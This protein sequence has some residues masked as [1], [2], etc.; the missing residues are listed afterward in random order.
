MASI[1]EDTADRG[2]RAE[3]GRHSATRGRTA[4]RLISAFV[5]AALII[6]LPLSAAPYG[7]VEAWWTALFDAAVFLLAA[8][9]AVEGALAGRWLTSAHVV[10]L[11]ILLLAG[12]ATLQSVPLPSTGSISFDP[13]ES[14]LV[15]A[16][17]LAVALY[18]ALLIRY[19]D[20]E[21]RLKFLV[22][23]V[24]LVGLASAFFGIIRQTT[25]RG[26]QGFVL[27]YLS[28]NSGY[29]QF[30]NKNH[31]A[32]LAEMSLGL[33]LGL[34]AGR[35]VA[36]QKILVPLALAVPVWAALVLSNSRGGVLAM[37]C[38][39][40]FLALTFGVTRREGGRAGAAKSAEASAVSRLA[41]S[42]PARVGLAALLLA[43]IAVGT[44][45]VG[46]DPLAE[47]MSAVASEV[48]AEGTDPTRTGRAEIW[49]ATWEMFKGHP[50]AGTGLGGY[51]IA[52]SS[53]HDASGA[54]VPQQ[55]HNDYL[56]LLASGGVVGFALL[57]LFIY[58]FSRR[59]RVRLRGGTPFAR[60]AGLGALAGLFGVAVHSLFEF[61]LHVTANAFTAAALV[62][63]ASAGAW[64]EPKN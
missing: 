57:L 21:G 18:C 17:L 15:A 31:F 6:I 3:S 19:A 13:Y 61:G 14:R 16:R 62:A 45:W 4:A 56:E 48:T 8:L 52:V 9:W 30:V 2:L 25:Q 59:A 26:E 34:A 1:L 29:A 58:L 20:T 39:V 22:Y 37:L 43:I 49:K 28:P 33:L 47:R 46:G 41:A 36:R 53:Y 40:V 12:W 44:V 7:S 54:G 51:W 63:V 24:V 32:Y 50:F 27:Q 42:T 10:T 5:F 23:A 35:G 60:A 11:P 64:R 38:Q 55:A